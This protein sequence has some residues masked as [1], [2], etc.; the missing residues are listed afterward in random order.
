MN[1]FLRKLR[2]LR[3]R[4]SKEQDLEAEL[5][6]HLSEEATERQASGVAAEE[7]RFAAQRDLGNLTL[8]KEKTRAMWTWTAWEAVL[9]DL[10]FGLRMMIRNPGSTAIAVL[11]LALA[12]G[13]N[14]AIFSVLNAALLKD[15]PVHNPHDLVMLSDPNASMVLGGVLQGPRSVFSYR[16]FVGLRDRT[17]TMSG[18]CASQLPLWRWPVR[19]SGGQQEEAHGRVVSENYFSF[20]GIQPTLGRFFTRHDATG[21]GKDPYVVISYNYWQRRFGG[22]KA[23]IGTPVRFYRTTLV[24]IGVAAKNFRGET[25]GQDPDLWLPMHMQ[26][27][28]MP[29]IDGLSEYMGHAPDKLMWLHVFG[30]RKPGV[31]LAKVQAEVNVL[32]RGFL[33]AESPSLSPEDRKEALDE[34]ILVRPFR[35]GAFHGRD[36]FAEEWIILAALAGLVLLVACANVANLLLARAA[37]RSR[38]VAIR[39]SIGAGRGRLIRQFLAESLLLAGLGGMAGIAVALIASRVLVLLLSGSPNGLELVASLDIRVLAFTA[40]ATLLT[41]IFF[42]LVPALRATRTAVSEDLKGTGRSATASRQHTAFAKAFVVTQIALSLLLV[43]GAGLFLRTLWNLQSLSLGYPERNLLLVEV[44]TTGANNA[45]A[46]G[47]NLY[48]EMAEGI[49]AIPGVRSVTWSDRGLFSGFDGSFAIQ[50]EGFTSAKESD[51]GSTGDSVGP[52][53]FSTI[54]IPMLLGREIGP[55]DI[56]L[57]RP[58][59]VINESF[60]KHFFAGRNPIG[61][62]VSYNVDDNKRRSLEIVG[63]AQNARVTSLRGKI[64]PKFYTASDQTWNRSWIEIRTWGD[65]SRVSNEVRKAI[66]AVNGRLDIQSERTLRETLAAQNAQPRLVAQLCSIFGIL[67]LVLA[68]TGIYGVLSYNVARRTNEIGIRMALGAGVRRVIGMILEETGWMIAAGVVAGVAIAAVC[69][70]LLA[71]QLYGVADTAPRWSLAR[72]EHV[73]SATQLYGI[74]AMDPLTI[75]AAIGLLAVVALLAAYIPATRAAHVDPVRA[76]RHE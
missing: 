53:Y 11:T 75:G 38:E 18:L 52:A 16:E 10:R 65:P 35:N 63:V 34:S 36:E 28:V 71:T 54:G 51:R 55:Q 64:D 67:A 68:A 49:R 56:A 57:S 22:S 8:V 69:T 46:P 30:R 48:R 42:G 24:I 15:L 43:M 74:T 17:Q 31:A 5:Q 37:A 40:C 9:Q 1:S 21:I 25:V 20:F 44:D 58:V 45:P 27:I 4:E 61:R 60:A 33:K 12:I 7:A 2:W 19:I 73:D 26:P 29:G 13:L 14:T 59:C 41:G 47:P 6:F 3:R 32:F 39:L 66:L 76:L 70:R 50:V 62:H 23:I 72:Y